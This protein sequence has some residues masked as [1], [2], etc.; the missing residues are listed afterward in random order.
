MTSI[1]RAYQKG[2]LPRRRV[3]AEARA[4]DSNL[5]FVYLEDCASYQDF[6]KVRSKPWPRK[7]TTAYRVIVLVAGQVDQYALLSWRSGLLHEQG[8]VLLP[9]FLLLPTESAPDWSK[10]LDEKLAD[11]GWSGNARPREG[12][13]IALGQCVK[14]GPRVPD[15]TL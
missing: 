5:L 7:S 13:S 11:A 1:V 4:R 3:A 14:S 10:W 8:T 12:P 15:G 9:R 2:G 6:W